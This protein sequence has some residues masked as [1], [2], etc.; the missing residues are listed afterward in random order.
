MCLVENGADIHKANYSGGT[1]L[2]NSVQSVN[3]CRFLLQLGADVN[4]ADVQCKTALHYAVQEHNFE[5]TKLLLEYN[6]NPYIRSRNNDDALQTACLKAAFEIFEYLGNG[7]QT[8]KRHLNNYLTSI[9]TLFIVIQWKMY[10]IL[11]RD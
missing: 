11:L 2:I 1:C 8:V 9:V 10:L 4:A 7:N 6:A 5:S 3:L